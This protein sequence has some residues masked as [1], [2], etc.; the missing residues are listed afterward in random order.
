MRSLLIVATMIG[1]G[2]TERELGTMPEAEATTVFATVRQKLQQVHDIALAGATAPQTYSYGCSEGT[3]ELK[4]A[5]DGDMVIDALRH[6]LEGC[7]ADDV[8][9]DGFMHYLRIKPCADESGFSL[10]IAAYFEVEGSMTGF[11]YAQ[12]QERCGQF[13]GH[14]CGFNARELLG[15]EHGLYSLPP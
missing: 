13:T 6:R 3:I 5:L 8:V 10:D 15:A 12:V 7:L 2:C 14:L 1:A 4:V 9:L 11:C